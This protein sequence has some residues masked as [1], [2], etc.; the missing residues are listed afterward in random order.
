MTG[1]LVPEQRRILFAVLVTGSF[2]VAMQLG[3]LAAVQLGWYG[4]PDAPMAP[5]RQVEVGILSLVFAAVVVFALAWFLPPD[6]GFA[7]RRTGLA[8]GAY[9]AFLVPWFL[10]GVVA[11]TALL[12]DLERPLVMQP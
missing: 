2:L 8:L 3:N 4:P 7:T 12:R 5:A 6:L 1:L 10:V 11:W 9:A